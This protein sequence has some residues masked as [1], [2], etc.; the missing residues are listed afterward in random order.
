MNKILIVDDSKT[1]RMFIKMCLEVAIP[2]IKAGTFYEAE[3]G[4]E[5]LALLND[6]EAELVIMDLNMPLMDGST[7]LR[8]MKDNDQ[9]KNIPVI[10]ITSTNNAAKRDE[11]LQMGADHILSKPVSP[12]KLAPIVKAITQDTT[13]LDTY[14]A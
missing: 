9:L 5:A 13:D 7:L 1:S 3:N 12:A 6:N 4:K 11:L 2:E 10:V 14:G 8:W